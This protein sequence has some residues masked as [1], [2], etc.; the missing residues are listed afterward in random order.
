MSVIVLAGGSSLIGRAGGGAG[1]ATGLYLT[2][3]GVSFTDPA[4]D[5]AWLIV[6][7][8]TNLSF[9]VR[10]S[11]TYVEKVADTTT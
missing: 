5:G 4:V 3:T 11:G 1:G 9:Q 8:G 7:S 2:T 6:V 10:Q